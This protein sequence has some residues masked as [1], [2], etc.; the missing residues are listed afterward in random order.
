ML[1]SFQYTEK[2][3]L[4]YSMQSSLFQMKELD[5]ARKFVA[6]HPCK[7]DMEQA[8]PVCRK[9]T[10]KYFF[11]KWDVDYLRCEKC[12][13]IYAVCEEDTVESYLK[14]QPLLSLRLSKEYQEQI[15]N[16]R[17]LVWKEFLEWL[18][19]R[20]Y[21]FLGRNR[22]L[23]I[24][25]IGNRFSGLATMIKASPISQKYDCREF[26]HQ[27]GVNCKS[28]EKADI[29][30]YNDAIKTEL[31]PVVQLKNIKKWMKE[32]GILIIGARAGSGFDIITL[33]ENNKRIYPYEHVFLPSVRGMLKILQDSGFDVLEI[34][35]PGVMDVKYVMEDLEWL[36]DREEFVK[37]LLKENNEAILQE[38][39]RFLQKSCMSS[40][41]R[42][43]ARKARHKNAA[44]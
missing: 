37:Y 40:F 22:K 15:T 42:V 32:D 20:A 43:I 7:H 38:F 11:T 29:I 14:H 5:I 35:T 18:E 13:S 3:Y 24:I 9:K 17:M 6:S 10:G 25:D 16:S 19:V 23:N 33:K 36:E 41:I 12:N 21:R 2:S 31:H 30:F 26:I 34:T 4:K 39:Q 28:N 44:I 8:C 27:T 1:R